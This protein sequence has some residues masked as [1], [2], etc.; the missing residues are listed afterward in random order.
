MR[1]SIENKRAHPRLLTKLIPTIKLS[2]NDGAKVDAFKLVNLSRFGASLVINSNL[3][4]GLELS[5]RI[6]FSGENGITIE[7]LGSVRRCE[8][9]PVSHEGKK[10]YYCGIH[11]SLSAEQSAE[12]E[13]F[14]V[15][16][17]DS[18]SAWLDRRAQSRSRNSIQFS[19]PGMFSTYRLSEESEGVEIFQLTMEDLD[20]LCKVEEE[21]WGKEMC[22]NRSMLESRLKHFS[23]GMIGARREGV[24]LG[25]VGVMMIN[26]AVCDKDFTWMGIT[27]GGYIRSTHNPEG[28][29][30]YGV[31]LSVTPSAPKGLAVRLLKAAGKL[32]VR[33]SLK[34][35]LFGCRI[36][37]YHKHAKRMPVQEYINA[38]STTGRIIDPELSLYR[39]VNCLPVRV[40]PNYFEDP[41][42]L[43]YGVL[44]FFENPL[45]PLQKREFPFFFKNVTVDFT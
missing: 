35:I 25:Y 16:A 26:S 43:N 41:E 39:A 36:P 28:D 1:T 9:I 5:I 6:R 4:V 13:K 10:Q 38:K 15:V 40:I 8:L 44:V 30:L 20:S 21:A 42:S 22:A 31:S 2:L 17:T 12:L 37:L 24:L 19:N 32:S 18:G 7:G 27:D 14:M 3:E 11:L 23:E 34:G 29:C 45:Y 33:K